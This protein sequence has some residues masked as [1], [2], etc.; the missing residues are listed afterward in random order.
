MK[1]VLMSIAIV[2]MV[3]MVASCGNKNAKNGEAEAPAQETVEEA[4]PA[5]ADSVAA[6]VDTVASA[7][8][9]K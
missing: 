4:A 1:K 6:P 8:T 5:A 9:T 7:D 2:A 3:A